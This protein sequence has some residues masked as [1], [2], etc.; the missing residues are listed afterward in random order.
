[1]VGVG[2]ELQPF[3]PPLPSPGETPCK[4]NRAGKPKSSVG[5]VGMPGKKIHVLGCR[6]SF[7]AP[8]VWEMSL[9]SQH[10]SLGSS[11]PASDPHIQGLQSF[12]PLLFQ[13][14]HS[15]GLISPNF[16]LD[17]SDPPGSTPQ[18]YPKSPNGH[19]W[20]REWWHGP[21]P[22]PTLGYKRSQIPG[23]GSAFPWAGHGKEGEKN[24]LLHPEMLFLPQFCRK[25]Q[26][27][28]KNPSWRA[29]VEMPNQAQALILLGSE[30][31][32]GFLLKRWKIQLLIECSGCF[33]GWFCHPCLNL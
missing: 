4:W 11:A 10:H 24:L 19:L 12:F 5:R 26:E 1:M 31:R 20:S 27:V 32:H 23:S 22:Q 8:R 13:A 3:V 28:W 29:K 25:V 21:N 6:S 2:L 16:L 18:K 30:L 7:G 15:Q 17:S 33:L 9:E 14:F